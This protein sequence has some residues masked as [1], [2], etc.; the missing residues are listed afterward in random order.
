MTKNN[1][2]II[3]FIA[4]SVIFHNELVS[5]KF[6]EMTL[7]IRYDEKRDSLD[8]WHLRKLEMVELIQTKKPDILG[9]QEGLF[10]Q[11]QYL[12]SALVNYTYAGCGRDDG[13]QK[14][15][16]SAIYID[17]T[18]FTIYQSGTFW[19]SDTPNKVSV[20]WDAALPRICSYAQISHKISKKSV[21]IFN[22]HFDHKG[23]SARLR[24]AELILKK[25]SEINPEN[26][27]YILM[28]DFNA[29]PEEKP[30][31]LLVAAHHKLPQKING[32]QGTFNGFGKENNT[33]RIDFIF[34]SKVKILKYIHLDGKRK[35]GR[36]IS[37]H[38]PVYASIR[39]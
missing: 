23:Q 2:T 17:T 1:F 27:P 15:E 31:Q 32:P 22:T 30:I 6:N 28:G 21:W 4:L 5:Q 37:D 16:F 36:Y 34:S 18:V 14:G 39:L 25:V 13:Y 20:G 12:D 9:I 11:V 3:W 7:N 33:R 29:T 24:S 35:N 8:N 10:H 38:L 19:L 26:Q